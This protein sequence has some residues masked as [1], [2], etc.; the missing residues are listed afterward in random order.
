VIRTTGT[1][2]SL[3][4]VSSPG[5]EFATEAIRLIREGP[6]WKPAEKNGQVIDDEVRVRI[7][8]K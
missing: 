3:K 1:I 6:A 7:V 2:D 8:F 4:V 5:D